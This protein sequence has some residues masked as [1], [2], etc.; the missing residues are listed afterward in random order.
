MVPV[1][2]APTRREP[3][4]RTR[5]DYD[6]RGRSSRCADHARDDL[7]RPDAGRTTMTA[8]EMSNDDSAFR[9]ACRRQRT[10]RQDCRGNELARWLDDLDVFLARLRSGTLDGVEVIVAEVAGDGPPRAVATMARILAEMPARP[11]VTTLDP[12]A[13]VAGVPIAGRGVDSDGQ[14]MVDA[15]ARQV[16][17]KVLIGSAAAPEDPA[18]SV[19]LVA[20]AEVRL[21]AAVRRGNGSLG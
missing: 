14:R 19:V 8:F 1:E 11:R 5:R 3:S 2:P 6:M 7:R 12:W 15:A 17:I 21:R 10:R 13:L 16:G 18:D 9:R 4:K 20:M